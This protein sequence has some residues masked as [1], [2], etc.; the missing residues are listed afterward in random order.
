M[1]KTS[2]NFLQFSLFPP[3]HQLSS[4]M[5]TDK[6]DLEGVKGMPQTLNMKEDQS[7]GGGDAKRHKS[8]DECREPETIVY[9]EGVRFWLVTISLAVFVFMVH[10]EIPIVTTAL[11][12]IID[13]L[14]GFEHAA[15]V[16]SS[17][18]LGYVAVI[19]IL[20]KLSDILG[21]KPVYVFSIIVFVIF[22]AACSAAQS[23]TQLITFRAFQGIGGGGCFSLS[24]VIIT[25][26]VPKEKYPKYVSQLS[27]ATSLAL[28]LGPIIGGAI[29]SNT[30]WRWVFII[31]VPIGLTAL[32]FA[33]IGLPHDFP[34]QGRAQ[35]NAEK[36]GLVQKLT[37]KSSLVRVDIPGT[38]LLLVAVVF[39]TAGF[40]EAD[41][42]FPWRS[43]Y[44]IS[45][46][47]LSAICWVVLLLWERY[48]TLQDGLREPI[49]TW[50]FFTNRL[51][52]G[53][54]LCLNLL[55]GPLIVSIFQLPQRFQLVHG[56]S[57]I[58]AGTR[59]LPFTMSM[60][61]GTIFAAGITNK[62]KLPVI[63]VIFAGSCLQVIG[64][65]LLGTLPITTDIP[66]QIYAFQVLAG[67]GGGMSYTLLYLL[68]PQTVELRDQ[69]VG[70][71]AASQIRMIGGAV[72]M[73][74]ATSVFNSHVRPE[75]A[76]L[77][78]VS[79]LSSLLKLGMALS[80][81]AMGLQDEVRLVLCEGY[82]RQMIVL[83]VCSALQIPAVLLLW[84]KKQ[85]VV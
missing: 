36:V 75:L 47:V 79:D 56:L 66:S 63:F 13:D 22:S 68:I 26:L 33:H 53:I 20:A 21:R 74:I 61:V 39:L 84:K 58:Q 27:I 45:L 72:T 76:G 54:L 32:L 43:A 29:S 5:E 19:V 34:H 80:S 12:S 81:M 8:S 17:Y 78:G 2:S 67:F 70:M 46:L 41:A 64:F 16:I 60:P 25:E 82:N 77:L 65:A 69:A 50:R 73:A 49:L 59:I 35:G 51:M 85:L 14:G 37:S 48:V 38:F 57:G 3:N 28:L 52:V 7:I 44:V 31:N 6:T 15:W 55:G 10:L 18:L 30:N 40:E 9:L 83:A 24:T 4:N 62:G 42:R 71:G 11:V 1:P 23:M